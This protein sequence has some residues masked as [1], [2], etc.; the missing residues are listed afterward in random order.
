M[1]IAHGIRLD[2]QASTS[3]LSLKLCFLLLDCCTFRNGIETYGFFREG[4]PDFDSRSS[5]SGCGVENQGG[6]FYR[7]MLVVIECVCEVDGE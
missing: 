6:R 4:V 7:D 2:I 5:K 3:A 1:I